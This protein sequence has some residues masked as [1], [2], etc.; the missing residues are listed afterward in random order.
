MLLRARRAGC[1][2][3]F[4]LGVAAATSRGAA[5]KGLSSLHGLPLSTPSNPLHCSNGRSLLCPRV[6]STPYCPAKTLIRQLGSSSASLPPPAARWKVPRGGGSMTS[7]SCTTCA[8][9]PNTARLASCAQRRGVAIGWLGRCRPFKPRRTAWPPCPPQRTR[10]THRPGQTRL[11]FFL[12]A[13][14]FWEISVYS[15]SFTARPWKGRGP[16]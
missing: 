1:C 4:S 6:F 3:R 13:T 16:P 8:P 12:S 7:S 9:S 15:R 10:Q 5:P 2:F 14:R 11:W